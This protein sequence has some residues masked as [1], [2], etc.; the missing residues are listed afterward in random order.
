MDKTNRRTP[1]T[2]ASSVRMLRF[3]RWL[4]AR[5]SSSA[6]SVLLHRRSDRTTFDVTEK[7]S[8]I[9]LCQLDACKA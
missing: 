2:Q 3:S 8:V 9:S 4:Q 5:T 1:S 7:L 6:A